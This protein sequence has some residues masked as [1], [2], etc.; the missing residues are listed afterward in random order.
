MYQ[1]LGYLTVIV[2]LAFI[3]FV[4]GGGLLARRWRWVAPF[5]LAALGWGI[6]SELDWAL[7]CPLTTLQKYFDHLAGLSS[8]HGGFV[9]HYLIPFTHH[10]GLSLT[11]KFIMVL[12]VIAFNVFAYLPISKRNKGAEN[13]ASDARLLN[14]P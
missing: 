9:A 14:R 3:A 5:Q 4:L 12:M 8:Y 11:W 7:T 10:E 6:L 2:H 1:A 13:H